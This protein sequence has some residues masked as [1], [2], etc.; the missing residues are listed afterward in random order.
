[1]SHLDRRPT[2]LPRAS[3]PTLAAPAAPADLFARL[4]ALGIAHHTF[5]HPP[6]HTVAESVALR[7]ALPGGHCKSLF[8]RDRKGGLWLAVM[9]EDRRVDLKG[10]SDKLAAPRFSFA[11]AELLLEVLGVRPGSVTP[12]ALMNDRALRV[13]PVL[14]ERMLGF[15]PLNYHPLVNTATTAVSPGGLLAFIAAT[16]HAP[17]VVSLDGLDRSAG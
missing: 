4:D 11:S 8:L 6:L 16:G 1:M 5:E 3:A 12:F 10:L 2:A 13:T 15:D 9:L 17:R 7:G 14:D